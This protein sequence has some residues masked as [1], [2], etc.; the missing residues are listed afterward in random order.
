VGEEMMTAAFLGGVIV[1]AMLALGTI[2]F[3]GE[4]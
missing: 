3:F 1:G 2:V 4:P